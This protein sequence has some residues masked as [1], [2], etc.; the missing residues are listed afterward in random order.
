MK[1]QEKTVEDHRRLQEETFFGQEKKPIPALLGL[2]N[3]VLHGVS[4]PH[5][6]RK[7]TLEENIRQVTGA[8]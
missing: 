5:I 6:R 2:M 7:N 1:Q 4:K 3:M 8:I